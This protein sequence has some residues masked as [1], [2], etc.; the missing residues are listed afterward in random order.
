MTKLHSVFQFVLSSRNYWS[1]NLLGHELLE[2][3]REQ[4]EITIKFDHYCVL[5]TKSLQFIMRD[6][7]EQYIRYTC[8]MK[9][10]HVRLTFWTVRSTNSRT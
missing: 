8:S 9:Y 6:L 4:F 5:N 10:F 2:L 1:L 3:P 7:S